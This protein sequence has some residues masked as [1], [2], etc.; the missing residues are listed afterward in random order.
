MSDE[1]KDY[2]EVTPAQVKGLFSYLE[3]THGSDANLGIDIMLSA[4]ITLALNCDEENKNLLIEKFQATVD[5][6]SGKRSDLV[7]LQPIEKGNLQ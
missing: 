4:L 1:N 5:I 6:L 7:F 3:T 2:Y